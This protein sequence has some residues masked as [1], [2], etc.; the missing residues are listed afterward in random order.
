[1]ATLTFTRNISN[2]HY[3]DGKGAVLPVN[4]SIL[5]RTYSRLDVAP[6]DTA[7]ALRLLVTVLSVDDEGRTIIDGLET[8]LERRFGSALVLGGLSNFG[9]GNIDDRVKK[10]ISDIE[11]SGGLRE[12]LLEGTDDFDWSYV[13]YGA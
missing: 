5:D 7:T 8:V 9:A 3:I 13:D 12:K 2:P 4:A 1:M 6:S 10:M 11:S